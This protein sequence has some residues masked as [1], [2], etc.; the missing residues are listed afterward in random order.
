[1]VAS[2]LMPLLKLLFIYC[3]LMDF[4]RPD[5]IEL[6]ILVDRGHREVPIQA[7]YKGIFVDTDP[8]DMIHVHVEE[9]DHQDIVFKELV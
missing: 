9:H 6:A 8:T 7:D 3:P 1:M 5:R 2:F 4:G